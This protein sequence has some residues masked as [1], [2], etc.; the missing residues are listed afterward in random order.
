MDYKLILDSIIALANC[1]ILT[2]LLRLAVDWSKVV[3]RLDDLWFQYCREHK[4]RFVPIS[5][6]REGEIRG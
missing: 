5:R 6:R 2:I 1:G 3:E 4:M